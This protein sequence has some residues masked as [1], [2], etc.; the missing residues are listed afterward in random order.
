MSRKPKAP[1][2]TPAFASVED[3]CRFYADARA[4]LRRVMIQMEEEIKRV[5]EASRPELQAAIDQAVN[6]RTLLADTVNREAALFKEPRTRQFHGI[7]VGFQKSPDS[8]DIGDEAQVIRLVRELLPELAST[9]IR[10]E[11]SVRIDGL[12]ALEA[13]QRL[14]L[15][16]TMK[17]GE[18]RLVLKA[19]DKDL[20]KLVKALSSDVTMSKD[21]RT[22]AG[23]I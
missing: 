10:I 18:D 9:L 12:N 5:A 21:M 22:S 2:N 19:A 6:A 7:K 16:V 11:E 8:L 3:N 15:G 23:A 14:Q 17:T 20:D 1:E 4:E 13:Q